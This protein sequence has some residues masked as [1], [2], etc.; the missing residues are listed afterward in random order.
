MLCGTEEYDVS[1]FKAHHIEVYTYGS[2]SD[3]SRILNWFWIVVSNFSK[4]E[5][6]RL[7]QFTTGSSQLPP[8]GFRYLNP[9]FKITVTNDFSA[10]PV[11]YTW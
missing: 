3:F 6:A 10:L 2:P 7:L 11:A 5:M 9:T 4:E 8:G 1:D